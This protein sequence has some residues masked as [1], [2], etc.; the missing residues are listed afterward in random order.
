MANH[1][2]AILKFRSATSVFVLGLLCLNSCAGHRD[3]VAKVRG[4]SL[5]DIR[6]AKV[7][8]VEVREEDLRSLPT[9]QERLTAFHRGARFSGWL[10]PAGFREPELPNQAVGV[11]GALLPSLD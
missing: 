8:V 5:S 1:P 10:G 2:L 3:L 9:G 6:P 7:D 11:D 4:F